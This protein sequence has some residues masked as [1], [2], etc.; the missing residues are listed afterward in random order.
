MTY[1]LI[2]LLKRKKIRLRNT[3]RLSQSTNELL[4][5]LLI[6]AKDRETLLSIPQPLLRAQ[7]LCCTSHIMLPFLKDHISPLLHPTIASQAIRGPD[8][9]EIVATSSRIV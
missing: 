4:P 5:T 2:D 7:Y 9:Q 8:A 3:S 6:G 1:M